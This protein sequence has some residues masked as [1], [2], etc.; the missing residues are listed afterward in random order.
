ASVAHELSEEFIK[1]TRTGVESTRLRQLGAE[2]RTSH[3][4]Q[5]IFTESLVD[6]SAADQYFICTACRATVNVFARTLTSGELSGPNRD[7]E[8]KRTFVGLCTYLDIQSA[9]ICGGLFDLNWPLFD[10]IVNETIAESNSICGLLPITICQIKQDEY[11]L[12][13]TYTANNPTTEH[14]SYTTPSSDKDLHVL[15]LTDIHYDP[16]YKVGGWAATCQDPLCCRLD[17]P[18]NSNA[19][20][21]GYWSDYN[22]CDSP[23]H[24]IVN[25]FEHISK[26]HKLNWIYH[27]GDVPPHNVWS[28]TKQGNM[29]MLT[30]IDSL[31]AKHFPETPVYSCLGNHE[32]HPTNVFGN[33]AV[34]AELKVDWLYQHVWSLWSKW[35]PAEAKTTVLRGGYYTVSPSKGYRIIALNSMDCY[36]FNWWLLYD[37][38]LVLEQLQW[39]HDTL[40]KAE[41]AGEVVH[42]LSHIPSGD[43]DCW[44]AWSA[45]YNRLLAH[46]RKTITGIFNG[47]THKDE[48]N[49]HYTAEGWAVAVSW[50]GGSLTSLSNKNPNYRVYQVNHE[51]WKVVN[52]ETH[53]FNLTAANLQPDTPPNWFKEYEFVREYT[54]DMSPAGIHELLNKMAKQPNLLRKFWRF[55]H[56]QADP[57]LAE[58]CDD[59][60]LSQTI[61]RMA[62]SNY[63]DKTRCKQLQA[64]LKETV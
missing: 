21:A 19:A 30:E 61:C 32:P 59:K 31:I 41:D 37:G 5:E 3:S 63:K 12:N 34:P 29:D 35:L 2:L 27:T 38:S 58:G 40:Q 22:V 64:I 18:A 9:E 13:V 46:F 14:N 50:N 54:S 55:K 48:L 20:G 16:E 36:L 26:T 49:V 7:A 8:A 28:T 53:I 43:S 47:H 57:K 17:L 25:A 62:T 23:K 51:N 52:Y 33:E 1:Y 24:M 10:F 42:I 4:R 44:S 6:L 11:K 15:Q 60:C 45:E 56:A 39:L